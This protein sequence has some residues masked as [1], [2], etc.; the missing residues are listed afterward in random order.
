MKQLLYRIL[1]VAA[2]APV[3]SSCGNST[4][5]DEN[6]EEKAKK[7]Y[8]E[9]KAVK[10]TVAK[11]RKGAFAR[12]LVSNGKLKA[13]EKAVVP[14]LVQAQIATLSVKNGQRVKRGDLLCNVDPAKFKKQLED[15]RNQYE[16]ARIDLEDQLLGYGYDLKDSVLVPVNIMKMTKIRSGYNQALSNLREAER[17]FAHT[18]VKAPISGVVANLEAQANN[19]SSQYKKCCEVINDE[20]LQVEFS[21]LEGEMRQVQ[22]GQSVGII[23]FA[24]TN[25][26]YQGVVTAINPT[27]DEYGMISIQAM[28]DNPKGELMDGMNAKML[29]KNEQPGSIIIPKTAVLYRQNRKVVFVYAKGIANWVYVKVG[30]ENS[31]DVT[32]ID[33]SLKPGQVVIVSNNLNLAHETPVIIE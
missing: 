10:V 7:S 17:N 14:F 12:E 33:N 11:V 1:V 20:V 27:I 13:R 24:N 28:V 29:V 3:I 6:F 32:I 4:K 2:L 5:A 31:S 26:V 30:Q 16:K 22:K 19:P 8:V 21:V 9:K 15:S 25:K 23:P 18:R